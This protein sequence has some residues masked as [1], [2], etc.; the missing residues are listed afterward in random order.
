MLVIKR[1]ICV[2]AFF[3]ITSFAEKSIFFLVYNEKTNMD[4]F[5]YHHEFGA[6]DFLERFDSGIY[7]ESEI[8]DEVKAIAY[9][10]EDD[11]VVEI[12]FMPDYPQD[13]WYAGLSNCINKHILNN[14]DYFLKTCRKKIAVPSKWIFNDFSNFMDMN[15]PDYVGEC[16]KREN[17]NVN[18]VRKLRDGKIQSI[19]FD[20]PSCVD[21][22]FQ[23]Y[24]FFE[25]YKKINNLI[26]DI[27]SEDGNKCNWRNLVKYPE[28]FQAEWFKPENYLAADKSRCPAL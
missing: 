14:K 15:L 17:Y 10:A 1:I 20:N 3:A 9:I 23:N 18:I 5:Y 24:E 8:F 11:S 13:S 25:P 27:M 7:I 2:A 22:E 19:S 26:K 6:I 21:P 28:K 16:A 12:Y 4:K